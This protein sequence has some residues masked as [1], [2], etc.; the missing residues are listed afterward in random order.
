MD[1][2]LFYYNLPQEYIAQQPAS[3]RDHSKLM[4]L[5]RQTGAVE[6]KHFYDI[7][8]Y[9]N[10][11]DLLVVNDSKVIPARLLGK[12]MDTGADVETLLLRDLGNDRWEVIVRPGKRLKTGAKMVFGNDVLKA[13]ILDILDGGKRIV[14]FDYDKSKQTFYSLLDNIGQLPLPHYITKDLKKKEDYQTVY[15]LHPGSAAAPTAGFHFTEDLLEQIKKNGIDFAKVTLHIGLGTFRPVKED[16]IEDH[17]MHEEYYSISDDAAR[18]I[19][20]TK[21]N[22]GRVIT[23]GTTSCRTLEAAYKRHG[24]IIACNESTD[25]FIYP[26]YQFNVIDGLITNFHL[27][28]STLIM[29]V[30]AFAGYENTMHAY[31]IAVDREYRFYSFGDAMF[32]N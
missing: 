4:L 12:K 5:D 13:E 20:E 6:E 23:V 9:L 21:K 3:P 31:K 29:L 2:S 19:R 28:E 25:I 1:K 15:A 14:E 24:E 30:S 8:D 17:L 22:G 7:V 18:K 32:I 10:P 11:G 26:G 27:P 16:N